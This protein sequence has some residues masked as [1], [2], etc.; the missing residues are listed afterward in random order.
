MLGICIIVKGNRI[1]G[2]IYFIGIASQSVGSP[3][4]ETYVCITLT[5]TQQAG[6]HMLNTWVL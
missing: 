1:G 6:S 2:S 5:T 4:S 3:T